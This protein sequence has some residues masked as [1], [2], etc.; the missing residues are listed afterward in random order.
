MKVWG[1]EGTGTGPGHGRDDGGRTT[2]RGRARALG[3]FVPML[4]VALAASACSGSAHQA[5]EMPAGT[6]SSGSTS[7]VTSG[8]SAPLASASPAAASAPVVS[9]STNDS[10]KAYPDRPLHVTASSGHVTSVT[11]TDEGGA[12]VPGTLAGDGTWTPARTF[13]VSTTYSVTAV[14]ESDGGDSAQSHLQFTTLAA[15]RRITIAS[16]TPLDGETV[17]VGLPISVVF[18]HSVENRAEV[19]RQLTV[20]ARPAVTGAWHWISSTR[21]DYRPQW[22]WASGTHV[23]LALNL[24]GVSDGNGRW[25]ARDLSR[26]FT[27]GSSL[28]AVVNIKTHRMTVTRDGKLLR[29]LPTGTGKPGYDTWGGTMVVLGKLPVVE[30]DSCSV[31]IACDPGSPIYYKMKVNDDVRLT[32]SGTFV[33][34]APWDYQIGKANISHGCIHLRVSDA[35]WFY[36]LAKLGDVVTVVGAPHQVAVDNGF[37][38]WNLSWAQWLAGSALHTAA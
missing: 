25:G 21:V 26:S 32:P 36:G 10:G 16:I 14:A 22:Y 29:N 38:D 15:G 19:E 35:A 7:V 24:N 2:V 4:T 13:K 12:A 23:T 33:H 1:V 37:G 18:M 20:D 17:G 5:S 6:T 27:I 11:V 3:L 30:M 9:V 8:A 31:H 34:A 28:V